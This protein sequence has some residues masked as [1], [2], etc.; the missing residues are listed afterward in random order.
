MDQDP[1]IDPAFD[2]NYQI[3][4]PQGGGKFGETVSTYNFSV[5]DPSCWV[6]SKS[7]FRCQFAI[8]GAAGAPPPI[9]RM[10][11]F[12]EGA[13]GNAFQS[14]DFDAGGTTVSRVSTAAAQISALKMRRGKGRAWMNSVGASA[15]GWGGTFS[16][17][18]AKTSTG[19]GPLGGVSVLDAPDKIDRAGATS[20]AATLAIE[21]SNATVTFADGAIAFSASYIGATLVINNERFTITGAALVSPFPNVDIAATADWYVISRDTSVAS[22]SDLEVIWQPPLGVMDVSTEI[23]GGS[24]RFSLTPFTDFQIRMT[25]ALNN[26]LPGTAGAALYQVVWEKQP[27]LYLYTVRSKIRES[28]LPLTLT[29]YQADNRTAQGSLVMQVVVPRSTKKI[30]VFTQSS[31]AG[32]DQRFP[33][34]KFTAAEGNGT[35]VGTELLVKGIQ[36]TYAGVTLPKSKW[37][38][39]Y[40][41]TKNNLT[42]AYYSSLV[43]TDRDADYK[44]CDT[45]DPDLAVEAP[46]SGGAE[47]FAEWIR[48]GPVYSFEFVR[49][50]GASEVDATID[51][52]FAAVPTAP[53]TANVFVVAEY[54]R[55]VLIKTDNN[56]IV[57]VT[58]D[59][60]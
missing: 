47:S 22:R 25:E 11:A 48:R 52:E 10:L 28:S 30:H 4:Q 9:S 54:T 53:L 49:P 58:A 40:S 27:S 1:V 42:A 2:P 5:S 8:T 60:A 46:T 21:S 20:V 33:A 14:A 45:S 56:Q 50:A 16:E 26:Y 31:L 3:V 6:P 18:V 57:S 23:G 38:A 35:T 43:S 17:R 15:A 19:A 24:F 37:Q 41:A 12:A 13:V 36:V 55:V 59:N 51:I 34:S 32:R 44:I 39:E 29:E 7:F